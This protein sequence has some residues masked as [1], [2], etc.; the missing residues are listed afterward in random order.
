M[1]ISRRVDGGIEKTELW[2]DRSERDRNDLSVR[3]AISL[4]FQRERRIF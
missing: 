4:V 2:R 1:E 3:E